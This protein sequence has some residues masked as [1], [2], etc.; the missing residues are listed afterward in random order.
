MNEKQ[1]QLLFDKGIT[2]V[3][4][5]ALCSD[6]TLAESVGMVY[7]DGE[8]RVIQKPV[9]QMEYTVGYT[10]YRILYIHKYNAQKRYIT[11][12]KSG[13]YSTEYSLVWCENDNGVLTSRGTFTTVSAN[14]GVDSLVVSS[15]GKTLIVS[16]ENGMHY[17]LWDVDNNSYKD[18]GDIPSPD[19]EFYLSDVKS[20][21]GGNR[22]NPQ[23]S[24][25]KVEAISSASYRGIVMRETGTIRAWRIDTQNSTQADYN[26]LV[27]G[28]YEKNKKVLKRKKC[29][30]EP[31]FIRTAIELYDGS[32][33]L[34]SQPI[35]MFPSLTT[36]T[37]GVLNDIEN[38]IDLHTYGCELHFINKSHFEDWSDIVKDVIVF[39]TDNINIYDLSVDQGM[40]QEVSQGHLFYNGLYRNAN[41]TKTEY[42][43]ETTPASTDPDHKFNCMVLEQ[44]PQDD[45]EKDIVSKSVFYKLCSIG[46]SYDGA[47]RDIAEKIETHTLENITTQERLDADDY[48]SRSVLKPSFIYSYN[49]RLNIAS[50]LRCIF[51]GYGCF[52]PY[53]NDTPATYKF[54]VSI[55][56]DSGNRLVRHIETDIYQKQGLWF[57]Y[58]DSRAYHVMIFKGNDCILDADLTEH[59]GLNGAYYFKGLPESSE[60]ETPVNAVEPTYTTPEPEMLSNYIIQSEVNNPFVFKAEGYYKVGTGKI[61]AMSSNTQALSEGQFG[62]F[63]LLVFSESGIWALTVAN[64]GYYDSI[65]PLSREVLSNKRS[66]TQT[67]GAVF[68]VS[69]K[70]LMVV[71]GNQVKCVSEQLN[72]KSK[73]NDVITDEISFNEF[74]QNAFIAYDYRDSLLWIFNTRIITVTQ[75][76]YI[77]SIK[78]GTF[79]R[80]TS[81]LYDNRTITN[82]VNDYP[83]FLLS[84]GTYFY[85]LLD[86]PDI[87]V[88]GTI[89]ENEFVPNTYTAN[90]YSRPMKFENALAL[91]SIMQV[92]HIHDMNE[93]ATLTLRIF[94]SNDLKHWF[95]MTSIR[96]VPWKY[97]RFRYDFT[98]LLATDRFAGTMLI[99][100]ERR[101]NKL[102]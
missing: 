39:I 98:N 7:V 3:P 12:K 40:W 85:S 97:Y 87:N 56:T 50:V 53:D 77:Y 33:H 6:N 31:F 35:L 51:E 95:E 5:D 63:P 70:G 84:A 67:D 62:Q 26:N 4:S 38:T 76:P 47:E 75:Q 13:H 92:K 42:H 68:F 11:W 15:I 71:V 96:G 88:D 37:Y 64:T 82:T 79:G 21:A 22:S 74:L 20:R 36:N 14:E 65:H 46:R 58:P 25:T 93:N 55:K 94:A 34:I 100:Q 66:V 89:V 28:L 48:Y 69:K 72:G 1:Q 23:Q 29:F 90:L 52:M 16:D 10:T 49:S 99:T 73:T 61:M 102:R 27:V 43:T 81:D 57:Y 59:S 41:G 83:D 17:Y 54:Y 80:V 101:T 32:Y 9:R 24:T 8:H 78:S 44:R 2:N 18:I 86:R 45:I 60:P 19:V 30:C 91:K